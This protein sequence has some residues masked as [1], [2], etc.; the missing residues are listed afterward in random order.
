[1]SSKRPGTAVNVCN[2]LSISSIDMP[3]NRQ[4]PIAAKVLYTLNKP[5]VFIATV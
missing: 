4:A 1:M 2:A 5:V 3:S